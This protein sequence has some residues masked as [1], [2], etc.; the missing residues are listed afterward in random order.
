MRS[1]LTRWSNTISIGAS[2]SIEVAKSGTAGLAL[3]LFGRRLRGALQRTQLR[4]PEVSKEIADRGQP[5]GA[6]DEEVTLPVAVLQHE[7]RAVQDAQVVR[8]DL[9]GHAQPR[10]HLAHRARLVPDE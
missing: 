8:R 7:S 2:I 4:G 6:D 10:R 1:A 3:W 5:V 9:L